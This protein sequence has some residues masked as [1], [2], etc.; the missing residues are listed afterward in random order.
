[1]QTI[2]DGHSSAG[3]YNATDSCACE[4]MPDRQTDKG[5]AASADRAAAQGTFF[6]GS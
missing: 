2:S 1:L 4:R 5:S 3:A 6:P